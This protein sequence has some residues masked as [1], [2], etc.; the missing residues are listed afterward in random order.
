MR[1]IL[2]IASKPDTVYTLVLYVLLLLCLLS[3]GLNLLTMAT[4]APPWFGDG[5]TGSVA[6]WRY[7]PLLASS[8][9][10]ATVA[11]AATPR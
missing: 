1:N 3:T 8:S 11:V 5:D 10:A 7:R 9:L 2:E 6:D 4:V